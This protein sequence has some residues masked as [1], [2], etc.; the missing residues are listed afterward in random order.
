MLELYAHSYVAP[1]EYPLPTSFPYFFN[2]PHLNERSRRTS[3]G[4]L[5]QA[6]TVP[7]VSSLGVRKDGLP[8]LLGR[9]ASFIDDCARYKIDWQALG[10]EQDEARE[11]GADIWT[12]VDNFGAM[13]E[14]SDEYGEDEE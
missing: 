14:A 8:K 4:I 10:I 7:I 2:A 5:T 13:S 6:R 3:R 9:Y 11:L 12:I 1:V